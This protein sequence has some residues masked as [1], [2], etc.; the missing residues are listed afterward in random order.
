MI[1]ILKLTNG[2]EVVGEVEIENNNEVILR[3]PLQINYRYY[4]SAIPSV[5]FVRYVVF[6]ESDCVSFDRMHIMNQVKPRES[7]ANFYES[8]AAEYYTRI[9]QSIDAELRMLTDGE[10]TPAAENELHKSILESMSVEGT[11][12]N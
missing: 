4:I 11:T 2:V 12:V 8:V 5:S 1:T 3:H 9:E 10:P 7:F 6:A